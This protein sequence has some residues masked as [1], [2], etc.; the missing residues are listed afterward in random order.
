[1]N[2]QSNGTGSRYQHEEMYYLCIK[3][4]KGFGPCIRE[5]LIDDWLI[6]IHF[7]YRKACLLLLVMTCP[8]KTNVHPVHPEL[9]TLKV[10]VSSTS[11]KY[12]QF[13]GVLFQHIEA[14]TRWPPFSRWHFQMHF[15]KR[16][17]ISIS[18]KFVKGPINNI[19]S[20]VQIMAWHR[21]VNK[22][23]SEPIYASL[24]LNELN[25]MSVILIFLQSWIAPW[26]PDC[27]WSYS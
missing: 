25:E 7:F 23:L 26:L 8:N 15:V 3:S 11:C 1:M 12:A 24:G 16:K 27:Q 18:L 13:C 9:R 4:Q 5:R 20:L 6:D 19:P 10:G 22:P 17:W 2:K 14:E 21:P